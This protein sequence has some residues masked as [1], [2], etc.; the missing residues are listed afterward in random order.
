MIEPDYSK[1]HP[2]NFV[3]LVKKQQSHRCHKIIRRTILERKLTRAAPEF[4]VASM[5]GTNRMTIFIRL[6]IE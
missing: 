3:C 1:Q 5:G 6:I 4:A 2:V